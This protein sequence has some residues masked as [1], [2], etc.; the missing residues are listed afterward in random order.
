MRVRPGIQLG[1]RTFRTTLIN[2]SRAPRISL[3]SGLV[4]TMTLAVVVAIRRGNGRSGSTDARPT[5]QPL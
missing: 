4:P 2:H 5:D 1:R 3:G